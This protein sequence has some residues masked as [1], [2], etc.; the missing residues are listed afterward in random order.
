MILFGDVFDDLVEACHAGS[1][2]TVQAKIRRRVNTDNKA[3]C[4]K[5]SFAGLRRKTTISYAGSAVQLPSNMLGIDLVW[6]DTYEIEYISRNRH[7][8]EAKE[9]AYRYYTYPISSVLASV[10]D[11]AINQDGTTFVSDD[12]LATGETVVDEFFYVGGMDQLY[13]I[14]AQTDNLFTFTPAYRGIGNKTDAFIVVRPPDTLMLDLE[15]ADTTTVPTGTIDLHYW[16]APD[17]LRDPNDIIYLPSSDAL[18]YRTL[19][20][21]PEAKANRPV[22]KSMVDTALQECLAMN[23]DSPSPRVARGL[24]GRKIDFNTNHYSP[25]Y[26]AAGNANH[27]ISNWQN[28]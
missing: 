21:L 15:S 14:T 26:G 9:Y 22:S 20:R 6:D 1:N 4:A 12:L 18:T 7:S 19:N 2:P 24:N 10:D 23:P 3:I 28:Q 25:R 8:S 5:E 11:V 16:V 17:Y 13:Q 27:I